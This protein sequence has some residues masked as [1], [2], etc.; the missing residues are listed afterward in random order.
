M[1]QL[2]TAAFTFSELHTLRGQV[3]RQ[4]RIEQLLTQVREVCLRVDWPQVLGQ[5]RSG[6]PE[7]GRTHDFKVLLV[8]R[9]RPG[10]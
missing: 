6:R 5:S 8:L 9:G 4:A 1:L 3:F 7:V 10:G 2:A